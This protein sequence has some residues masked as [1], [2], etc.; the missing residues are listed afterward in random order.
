[1]VTTL[2]LKTVGE[3]NLSSDLIFRQLMQ[4]EPAIL[5]IMA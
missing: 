2:P 1:M 4:M 5:S 3:K